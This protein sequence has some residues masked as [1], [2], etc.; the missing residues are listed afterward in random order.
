MPFKRITIVLHAYMHSH[1]DIASQ[2]AELVIR[3]MACDPA[4]PIKMFILLV[5]NGGSNYHPLLK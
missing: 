3:F 5:M 2:E 1:I 4:D